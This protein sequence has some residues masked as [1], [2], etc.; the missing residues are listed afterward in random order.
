MTEEADGAVA[1]DIVWVFSR[2]VNHSDQCGFP[3]GGEVSSGDAG[4]E[5]LSQV[6]KEGDWCLFY[7][8]GVHCVFSWCFVLHFFEVRL[9]FT[10]GD[11]LREGVVLRWGVDG[12]PL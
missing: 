2:F 3:G 5:K 10:G 4:G 1:G 9:D 12:D 11:W 6:L 8:N 7:E